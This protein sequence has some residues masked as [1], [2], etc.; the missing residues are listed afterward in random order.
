MRLKKHPQIP[1]IAAPLVTP[2]IANRIPILSAFPYIP[3]GV[4]NSVKSPAEL[5][6]RNPSERAKRITMASTRISETNPS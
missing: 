1:T 3:T 6:T 5:T 2:A 4:R